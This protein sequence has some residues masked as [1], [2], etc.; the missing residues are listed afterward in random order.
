MV[1]E[2]VSD[3]R[4]SSA[5]FGDFHYKRFLAWCLVERQSKAAF[6]RNIVVSRV[7]SNRS[8]IDQGL[9]HYSRLYG[10]SEEELLEHVYRADRN[11]VSIAQLHERLEAGLRGEAAW[12][13]KKK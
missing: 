2:I 8:E 5:E 7:E 4:I 12:G 6:V 13:K 10:L 3:T 9:A 11:N 1:Y